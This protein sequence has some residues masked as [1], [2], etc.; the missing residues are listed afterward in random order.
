MRETAS[1]PTLTAVRR[2]RPGRVALEVDGRR[3]RT[4]PDA[5]V[6]A[7][8]LAPGVTLERPLLRALRRELRRAEALEAAART[9]ARRD[10]SERRL[11]ERLAARGVRPPAAERAVTALT[12]AGLVDDARLARSR[13]RALADRG[14][15]D[16]A[17][18]ARLEGEGFGRELL[19][20]ALAE[21]APEAERARALAAGARDRTR[22]WR[23]LARRG[24]APESVE[25]AL[26]RWTDAPEAGYD[27]DAY[28]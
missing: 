7:C 21:L 16:E 3:W 5:V 12:S 9:L 14:W 11:R 6:A 19:P 17:I 20:P 27:T 8:G 2:A 10:L 15:G 1:A 25:A 22:A 13:V 18:A 24:F 4:V 23:L 26:G 28:A